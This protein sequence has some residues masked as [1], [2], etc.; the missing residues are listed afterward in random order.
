MSAYFRIDCLLL[1]GGEGGG[2]GKTQDGKISLK[3]I[4]NMSVK[5]IEESSCQERN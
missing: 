4:K 3:G 1:G 2:G 5:L